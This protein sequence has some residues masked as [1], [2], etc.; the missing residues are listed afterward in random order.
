MLAIWLQSV[1]SFTSYHR[2]RML[3][4]WRTV[5][6]GVYLLLV[7]VLVFTLYF[8][9]Q[10]HVQLPQ[11]VAKLPT[12]TFDQGRLTAP[13][14]KII[15]SVPKTPYV[16][17]LDATAKNPPT[18]QE[19]ADKKILAFV[20]GNQLYMPSVTGVNAQTLPEK[21]TGTLTPQTIQPYQS[22]VRAF[23]QTAAFFGA[24]FIMGIFLVFS[25]LMA[26]AVIF[27][28]RGIRRAP[29]SAGILWRW[30]FFLQ[31]PALILWFIQ[32]F[33]GVPLFTFALFILFNIYVQQIFNTLPNSR[34][35]Y[36]A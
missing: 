20:S 23:L 36:A 33:Y 1:F 7:G 6:F 31:G 9:W 14:E 4:K 35:K 8:A 24:F 32:L 34:G 21:L 5:F 29:V 3:S 17:V 28:W 16:L 13:Q 18:S 22:S 27:F 19:F 2:L 12:L 25:I 10:L 15:L 26:A 11:F 30:A